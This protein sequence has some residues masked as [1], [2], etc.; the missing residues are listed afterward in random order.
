M[1]E[2][3]KKY[4]D[5][6]ILRINKIDRKK[7]SDMYKELQNIGV[8]SMY[9][10]MEIIP[11]YKGINEYCEIQHNMMKEKGFHDEILKFGEYIALIHGELSEALEA[12]RKGDFENRREELADVCLRVFDLCGFRS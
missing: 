3:T 4:Y 8:I 9:D 12:D 2:L 5:R 7:F 1:T 11:L 6:L 10:D